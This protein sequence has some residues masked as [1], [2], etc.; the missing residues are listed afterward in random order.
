MVITLSGV[1]RAQVGTSRSRSVPF[2]TPPL[3]RDS[4]LL[5]VFINLA[6]LSDR[7]HARAPFQEGPDSVNP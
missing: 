2:T 3:L 4:E 1:G 6:N 5:V 7:V